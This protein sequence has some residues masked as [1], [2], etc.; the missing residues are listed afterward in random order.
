MARS[1]CPQ[2]TAMGGVPWKASAPKSAQLQPMRPHLPCW[3][4]SVSP[5]DASRR[6]SSRRPP[7]AAAPRHGIRWSH[8]IDLVRSTR[9]LQGEQVARLHGEHTAS[10]ATYRHGC[11]KWMA[12]GGVPGKASE[13]QQAQPSSM[14]PHRQWMTAYAPSPR[15]PRIDWTRPV[16]Q[17]EQVARAHGP[18]WTAIG[19]VPGEAS[20]L[21]QAHPSSVRPHRPWVTAYSPPPWWVRPTIVGLHNRQPSAGHRVG[22]SPDHLPRVVPHTGQWRPSGVHVRS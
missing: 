20:E 1:H 12:I 8:R 3:P 16:V 9:D 14:R 13:L 6:V 4:A 7:T 19:G 18:Q 21:Q 15:A 11:H 22:S 17:G 5:R 10:L 2:W